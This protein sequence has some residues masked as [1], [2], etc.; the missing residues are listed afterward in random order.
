MCEHYCLAIATF[1]RILRKF[2]E[3]KKLWL[4]IL[5]DKLVSDLGFLEYIIRSTFTEIE[6]FI[7][8]FLN[9][10]ALSFFQGTS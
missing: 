6:T 5:E 4:G 3:H 2:K 1:Y 8:S 7:I 10:T 9:T